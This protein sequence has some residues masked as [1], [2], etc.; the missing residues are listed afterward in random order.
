[1][2]RKTC[3]PSCCQFGALLQGPDSFW[4]GS[5]NLSLS[6]SFYCSCYWAA[7]RQL[8][9][10]TASKKTGL[11]THQTVTLFSLGVVSAS[12]KSSLNLTSLLSSKLFPLSST[13]SRYLEPP[14]PPSWRTWTQTQSMKSP[15]CRSTTRWRASRAPKKGRQVS[16]DEYVE[17]FVDAGSGLDC[18]RRIMLSQ[19]SFHWMCFS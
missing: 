16:S 17:W 1:M 7:R 18:E 5:L 14:P 11:T 10:E 6:R 12:A 9:T 8:L 13:R 2:Q 19:N 3:T 15:S 4:S